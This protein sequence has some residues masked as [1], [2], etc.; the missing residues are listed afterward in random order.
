MASDFVSLG[1]NEGSFVHGTARVGSQGIS[2]LLSRREQG[3]RRGYGSCVP[4]ALKAH[5]GV[6][7]GH[8]AVQRARGIARIWNA[9]AL[10]PAPARTGHERHGAIYPLPVDVPPLIF[11]N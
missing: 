7:G 3:R 4:H 11:F 6:P 2:R 9:C 1:I 10:A 8:C 5:K